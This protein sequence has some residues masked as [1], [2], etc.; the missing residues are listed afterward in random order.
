MTIT[1]EEGKEIVADGV[2]VTCP[3]PQSFKLMEN[4][5]ISWENY[6]Y[7][8]NWTLIVTGPSTCPELSNTQT[9]SIQ[10]IRYGI[11]GEQSNNLIIHLKNE[12]S[13]ENL[14][15][16]RQELIEKFM[17]QAKLEIDNDLFK[18]IEKSD[19]HAHRWR[20]SRPRIIAHD[21]G[22]SRV[23]FAGDAFAHPIGTV[24]GAIKS[25]KLATLDLAWSLDSLQEK[26]KTIIQSKLF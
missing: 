11:E 20:F 17:Q 12:W 19:V 26:E 4:L 2:I 8:S 9:D 13:K 15:D 16:T 23:K 10:E 1:T 25:A 3:L 24:E 5:P 7:D 18:W 22:F 14:E 21:P 6:P